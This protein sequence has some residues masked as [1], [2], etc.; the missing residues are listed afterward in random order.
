MPET[1]NMDANLPRMSNSHKNNFNSP[2]TFEHW[3]VQEQYGILTYWY[4]YGKYIL[5]SFRFFFFYLYEVTE[6]FN[7]K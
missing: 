7:D 2:E 6:V 5:F 3:S 4:T 1:L